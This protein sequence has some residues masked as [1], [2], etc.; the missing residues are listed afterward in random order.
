MTKMVNLVSIYHAQSLKKNTSLG[1]EVRGGLWHAALCD[2]SR[3]LQSSG[4]S[5]AG[6][7]LCKNSGR[8]GGEGEPE[9]WE[10]HT[11]IL[12]GNDR[13]WGVR[14]RGDGG[15]DLTSPGA[16]PRGWGGI[17]EEAQ[18]SGMEDGSWWEEELIWVMLFPESSCTW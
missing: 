7:G 1:H 13:I 8:T 9:G 17:Q 11:G 5:Q 3:G 12:I 4:H 6:E 2:C 10:A 18:G 14:E 15:T 16:W